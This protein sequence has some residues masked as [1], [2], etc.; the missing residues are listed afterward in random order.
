MSKRGIF[1]NI[2]EISIT[3]IKEMYEQNKISV[4]ELVDEYLNNITYYDQG[5]NKLN[6][7]LEINP[8]ITDIARYL[9]E[10]KSEYTSPLYG[11]PILIK[12]NIDTGDKMHTSAGAL[13]LADLKASKDADVVKVL[14]EKGAVILGKTNMT[15]L[16]NYMTKGMPPGYSSRGGMVASP[17]NKTKSPSGSSTGSAVSVTANLCGASLGTDT[18]G[19]IISPAIANGI[20]GFCPSAGIL[21]TNG[22]LPVS[23]TLDT[24]GPM[25]RTIMD[26]ILLFSELTN[27][28]IQPKEGNL[29]NWVIGIDDNSLNNLTGE[30]EKKSLNILKELENLGG[31]IVRIKLP[32]VPKNNLKGIGKYEF[33]YS[34]NRY[35]ENVRKEFPIRSLRDIIKFNNAHG[36]KALKYGQTLLLEAEEKTKGDLSETE[37]KELLMDREEKKRIMKE[38]LDGIDICILFQ[39]NLILQY[40]GLPILS[41]P[42]G[43]YNDGMPYGIIVTAQ[44][45]QKLLQYGYKLEELIGY[46][47]PPKL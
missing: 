21:S 26:S 7:V 25:T 5:E 27:I 9:E 35:F 23:F 31:K 29:K 3:N 30:E 4:Q 40:T 12:D 34:L 13:A 17:Y 45:N 38:L 28:K 14:R 39:E 44:N 16:A 11:V 8:D 20:V 46:R 1:V 43:L 36:E 19:S 47:V 2:N 10:H 15:E 18:S 6:S 41:I 33:K 24:V 42:H 37:Y 22:I 32:T